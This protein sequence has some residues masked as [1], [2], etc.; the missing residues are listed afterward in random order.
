MSTTVLM[1]TQCEENYYLNPISNT[2]NL[3]CLL[4]QF[5]NQSADKCVS[6]NAI[7]K[8]CETCSSTNLSCLSCI[9]GYYY[10]VSN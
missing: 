4:N 8:N 9:V 10:N 5:Y 2:C 1:C 3:K 6:C 7:S